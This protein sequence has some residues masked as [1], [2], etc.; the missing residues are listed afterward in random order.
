MTK[1]SDENRELARFIAQTLGGTPS[2]REYFDDERVATINI[3]TCEDAPQAGVRSYSTLALSDSP[4]VDED[5]E[6]LAFGVEIVAACES[7]AEEFV[8]A[9]STCAFNIIKDRMPVHPGAVFE[10]VFDLYDGLSSTL[11]HAFFVDPVLWDEDFAS[12]EMKTKT[13]AFLQLIPISDAE[14]AFLH[15]KGP[16][17]LEDEFE[18]QQIDIFDINRPSV[19]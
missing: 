4:L 6:P 15:E 11:S 19:V 1:P 3:M 5:D 9:L 13:V 7:E 18:K 17:A 8:N 2:V 12:K 14:L 10:R 16:D